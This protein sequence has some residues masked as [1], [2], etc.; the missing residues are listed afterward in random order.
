MNFFLVISSLS[1]FSLLVL[2]TKFISQSKFLQNATFIHTHLKWAWNFLLLHSVV[3]NYSYQLLHDIPETGE[4]EVVVRRY[5]RQAEEEDGVECA[6][7]LCGIEE[8]EEIRELRCEHV[9]HKVCL[10]R[11]VGCRQ[12]TCPLCR[13]SLAPRRVVEEVGMEV[14]VLRFGS[15]SS[16]NRRTWW[17]R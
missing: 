8:G 9:F 7:C 12:M 10:D 5:K 17:L 1:L 6:V 16:R 4:E 2:I 11:W 15:Q 3:P 14:L 13:C